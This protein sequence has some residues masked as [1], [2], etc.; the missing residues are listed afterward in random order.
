MC[1]GLEESAS[2]D[3]NG[4]PHN[5]QSD[6]FRTE[7]SFQQS[8]QKKGMGE[9]EIEDLQKEQAVGRRKSRMRPKRDIKFLS[10]QNTRRAG[11]ATL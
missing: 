5:G 3:S 1:S 11:L 8:A 9:P 10:R 7:K 6:P 2:G 4:F